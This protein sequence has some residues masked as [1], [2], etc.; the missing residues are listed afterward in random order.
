MS[1]MCNAYWRQCVFYVPPVKPKRAPWFRIIDTF[2]ASPLDILDGLREI[3]EC[4]YQVKPRSIVLLITMS[5]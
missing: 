5:D 1:R 3:A 4:A 2:Q